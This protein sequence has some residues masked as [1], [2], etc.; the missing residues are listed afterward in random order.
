MFAIYLKTN[1]GISLERESPRLIRECL[2]SGEDV[3]L[4]GAVGDEAIS[5][6][7]TDCFASLAMT[8]SVSFQTPSRRDEPGDAASSGSLEKEIALGQGQ[9]SGRLAR[10]HLAVG[11]HH[12]R[13][14]IDLYMR[15]YL[16][17][18]QVLFLYAPTVLYRHDLF[19]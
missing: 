11:L 1:T 13:L 19:L 12:I 18:H 8:C 3:S 4:R 7:A 2:E 16:I 10:Q 15:H 17:M 14:R 5:F 6:P 9:R